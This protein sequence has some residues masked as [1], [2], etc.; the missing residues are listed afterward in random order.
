MGILVGMGSLVIGFL[1][2]PSEDP[3]VLIA[4]ACVWGGM[5]SCAFGFVGYLVFLALGGNPEPDFPPELAELGEEED[6][7]D[8]ERELEEA[9]TELSERELPIGVPPQRGALVD[10]TS[11][12]EAEEGEDLVPP[13]AEPLAE[14]EGYSPEE[15]ARA[16]KTQLMDDDGGR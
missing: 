8:E 6:L 10:V 1:G 16:V 14:I 12:P 5:F 2:A 3:T 15:L 11:R 13:I 9:D 4:R 7:D